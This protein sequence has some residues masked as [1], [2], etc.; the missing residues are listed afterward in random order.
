MGVKRQSLAQEV[1]SNN[2]KSASV[3]GITLKYG[4][5]L[6]WQTTLRK[7][8]NSLSPFLDVQTSEEFQDTRSIAVDNP[9]VLDLQTRLESMQSWEML[10]EKNSRRM[11]LSL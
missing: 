4:R 11:K 5:Q 1:I 6:P 3:W 8:K 2:L 10:K 7:S 9:F